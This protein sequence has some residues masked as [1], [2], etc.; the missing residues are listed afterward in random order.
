MSDDPPIL[1]VPSPVDS[2]PVHAEFDGFALSSDGGA[3]L[4][5]EAGRRRG[6]SALLASC[7]ADARDPSRVVHSFEAMIPA[8]MVAI[9]CG[10]EDCDDPDIPRHDPALKIAC[11]KRPDA[12]AGLA[13]QPTLSRPGNAVSWRMLARM[14]LGTID[15]FRD[16]YARVPDRIVLDIDDT[17]DLAHGGQQLPPFSAHAGD[18]C[19]QPIL[20]LEAG[21][22]RPVAAILRPGKR[23]SRPADRDEARRSMGA[24]TRFIVTPI[25]ARAPWTARQPMPPIRPGISNPAASGNPDA[26]HRHSAEPARMGSRNPRTP[27]DAPG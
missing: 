19:F 9:A 8:R 3:L 21:T 23:P 25:A 15:A 4:L 2:V 11:D 24:D 22:H 13:S 14:G 17:A 6:L 27:I 18:T 16:S 26:A 20:I 5:R 10:H 1:P 12:D 7:I